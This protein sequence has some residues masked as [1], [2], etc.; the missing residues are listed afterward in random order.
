MD[1]TSFRYLLSLAIQL[2]LATRLLDVVTANVYGDLDIDE[3]IKPPSKFVPRLPPVQPGH[4]HRLRIRKALYGLKQAR[5]AWYH[6]LKSYLISNGFQNLLALPCIFILKEDK[7]FV[8]LVVYVDDL[9][10]I[11]IPAL[12][13]RVK[14]ILT[15]QFEMKLLVKTSY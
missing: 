3:H 12:S 11:G 10:C 5:R 7:Q 6:H 9:N 13:K 4:F 8:I 15:K 1:S 14:L 2:S